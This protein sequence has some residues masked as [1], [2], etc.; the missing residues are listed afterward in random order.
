MG[1]QAGPTRCSV[2][3]GTTCTAQVWFK[4]I[5]K[6]ANNVNLL[7]FRSG[8]TGTG[9]AILGVFVSSTGKLGITNDA[10]VGSTTSTTSV[11]SGWHSL[12]AHVNVATGQVEIWLDGASIS[13]LNQTLN[14]GS[15]PVG[16]LQLGESNAN[17]TYDVAFDEVAY[18]TSFLQTSS[19]LNTIIDSGPLGLVNSNSASF[20]F[21]STFSGPTLSFEC[22]LDA[23]AFIACTSPQA[24]T[25]L[26][27]GS[28]TF[29]VRALDGLGGVD[30]TPASRVWTV[31]TTPPTVASVLPTDG[32][33]GLATNATVRGTFSE[34]AAPASI[35]TSSFILTTSR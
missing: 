6:G 18:D 31:D 19:S 27:D 15:S 3:P 8:T 22:S 32:A 13:L 2:P 35:S 25:G 10:G 33:T 23:S 28:H 17:R 16:R 21:S 30:Q 12:Q 26:A 20:N 5:S 29:A 1:R 11:T 4:V 24:Y 9:G 7:R 14:L 34:A